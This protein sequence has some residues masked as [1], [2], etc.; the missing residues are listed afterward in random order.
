MTTTKTPGTFGRFIETP[1]RPGDTA[2]AGGLPVLSKV[3]GDGK[4]ELPGRSRSGGQSQARGRGRTARD[5][6]RAAA[7]LT[8]PAGT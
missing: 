7:S 5:A 2:A 3:E 4:P 8:Q 6:L 1:V